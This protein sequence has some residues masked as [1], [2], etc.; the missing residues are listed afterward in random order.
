ML[1]LGRKVQSD[2]FAPAY[3]LDFAPGDAAHESPL[4]Y[5]SAGQRGR[6]RRKRQE[7]CLKIPKHSVG[8]R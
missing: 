4:A 3:V 6:R 1:L 5:E 8:F 2:P 7:Q